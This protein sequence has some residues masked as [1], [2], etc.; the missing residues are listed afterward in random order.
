MSIYGGGPLQLCTNVSKLL[1]YYRFKIM[2]LCKIGGDGGRERT[3]R[4]MRIGIVDARPVIP[5]ESPFFVQK[6][7]GVIDAVTAF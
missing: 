4:A 6:I 1:Y 7:I 5:S 3:T 2:F